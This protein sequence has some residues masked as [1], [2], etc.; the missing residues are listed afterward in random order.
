MTSRHE[1][2]CDLNF[3]EAP[4][5]DP[6]SAATQSSPLIGRQR[7]QLT[8]SQSIS[9]LSTIPESSHSGNQSDIAQSGSDFDSSLYTQSD[10]GTDLDRAKLVQHS[11]FNP[12]ANAWVPSTPAKV[13]ISCLNS[14]TFHQSCQSLG[15]CHELY[16][17][18]Q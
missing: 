12:S 4:L 7:S 11:S 18:A 2:A 8:S 14:T 1:R 5:I 3:G 9:R 16:S 15:S 17:S 13:S 10:A 6:M